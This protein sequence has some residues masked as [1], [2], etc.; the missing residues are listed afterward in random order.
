MTDQRLEEIR[1]YTREK[2]SHDVWLELWGEVDRLRDELEACR[3]MVA[4]IGQQT[5]LECVEVCDESNDCD[6]ANELR[7]KFNLQ[8]VRGSTDED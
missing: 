4:N 3:A 6:C 2:F 5:A 1:R 7:A 8:S